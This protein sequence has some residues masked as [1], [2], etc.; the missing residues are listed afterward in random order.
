MTSNELAHKG[1]MGMKWGHRSASGGGG[2][3]KRIVSG[4]PG[5]GVGLNAKRQ[6]AISKGDLATLD[7]GG[8]LSVG[9]TKKR[10][11]AYDVRDRK[12]VNV[13]LATANK[14]LAMTPEQQKQKNAAIRKRR[15]TV[16]LKLA[17]A[18]L[19]VVGTKVAADS[20]MKMSFEKAEKAKKM[21]NAFAS[22]KE[23]FDYAPSAL[24]VI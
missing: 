1:I 12:A 5:P 21:A 18:V 15:I 7:A 14:T 17:A 22:A 6:A 4:K 11:A 24:A 2:F 13:R 19:I 9:F 16:G 3:E 23:A 10:Q 8:H 20:I